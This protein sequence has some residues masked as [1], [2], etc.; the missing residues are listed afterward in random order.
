MLAKFLAIFWLFTI[1]I[2]SYSVLSFTDLSSKSG[3]YCNAQ[4]TPSNAISTEAEFLK[5]V[6][7]KTCS[8]SNQPKYIIKISPIVKF[9]RLPS[10]FLLDLYAYEINDVKA[11]QEQKRENKSRKQS[12]NK[13][14]NFM[15]VRKKIFIRGISFS[16]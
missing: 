4:S 9:P 2:S 11:E 14:H 13:M 8:S 7:S 12:T 15:Y 1:D 10:V 6:T 3:G 16:I 5:I